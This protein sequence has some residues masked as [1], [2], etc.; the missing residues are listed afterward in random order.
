MQMVPVK[1][2]EIIGAELTWQWLQEGFQTASQKLD[3]WAQEKCG[4]GK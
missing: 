2:G 4:N 3:F 1:H